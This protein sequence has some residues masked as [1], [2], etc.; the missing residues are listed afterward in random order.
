M[1]S[2][3]PHH[4]N[5]TSSLR[6]LTPP[7]KLKATFSFR[8]M[9]ELVEVMAPKQCTICIK[10]FESKNEYEKHKSEVH[11]KGNHRCGFCYKRYNV[12]SNL[13]T[14][15][16]NEHLSDQEKKKCSICEKFF[17]CAQTL[18]QHT[19]LIHG[20]KIFACDQC[21]EKFSIKSALANHRGRKHS[22]SRDFPCSQCDKKFH[23]KKD[24]GSHIVQV[25]SDFEPYQ[26]DMCPS[27]FKR[28][29]AWRFHRKTHLNAKNFECPVCLK[30]FKHR[31]GMAYCLDR[32]DNPEGEKYPCTIVNCRAVLQTKH[33]INKHIKNHT[34]GE[35]S[36]CPICT[37]ILAGN[38]NLSRHLRDVHG[39][40]AKNFECSICDL[41]WTTRNRLKTHMK[42]H[43]GQ[44][45]S[46]STESCKSKSN[47]QYGLNFHIKQK[48][49][50]VK[51]RKPLEELEKEWNKKFTCEICNKSFKLGKAPLFAVE[52]HK[53]THK[54]Q[55]TL[56]CIIENCTDKI[57]LTKN[58]R[59]DKTCNL[60][61]EFYKH[62]ETAHAITF[63]QFQIQA[64]F[65][66]KLC[67]E[68]LILR[69][70]KQQSSAKINSLMFI[71]N[72]NENLNMHMKKVHK[73]SMNTGKRGQKFAPILHKYFERK[74]MSL[75]KV[76]PPTFL[77][78][79]LA[80]KICKLNCD[81]QVRDEKWP[82]KMKL[83][84][85][86]CLEHF[87]A[88]LI[89]KEEMYFKGKH[90]PIC[91]QCDFEIGKQ[92]SANLTTKAVHIGVTHNEILPILT[93]YF[94]KHPPLL[95]PPNEDEIE[96]RNS[97]E[98][99]QVETD[100]N[101]M[102]TELVQSVTFEIER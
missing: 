55:Q 51:H 54:N 80:E 76:E 33:G 1:T 97:A 39:N 82:F 6:N 17:K 90:F 36:T 81:F 85:H 29:S 12:K 11:K 16:K 61:T 15:I 24:V 14:H 77:D 87:G 65:T 95:K 84:K 58:M 41:K 89:E 28:N 5:T 62:F 45:F 86:Y 99:P 72:W 38:S 79:L 73:E 40:Q 32:H 88:Q 3:N 52:A 102:I 8:K 48:H 67:D 10:I 69:S 7:Q 4:H 96:E 22:K 57:F 74:K 27:K 35:C 91:I 71:S 50:Q 43:S 23:D 34:E 31:P 59:I 60:P 46:C 9:E 21:E 47:T 100:M 42:I 66:C 18:A 20:E 93:S 63:D 53:R 92:G 98:A 49:G 75:E 56:D 2:F 13:Q 70:V 83:L 101:R 78:K 44:V 26:C 94:T 64:T 25:H 68:N 30:R 19:K 37:R